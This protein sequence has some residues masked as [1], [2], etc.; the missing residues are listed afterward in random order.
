MC[1]SLLMAFLLASAMGKPVVPV[2]LEIPGGP[3]LVGR[4]AAPDGSLADT[5]CIDDADCPTG[6]VCSVSAFRCHARPAHGRVAL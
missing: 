2:A 6:H 4:C 1:R 3:A 5:P